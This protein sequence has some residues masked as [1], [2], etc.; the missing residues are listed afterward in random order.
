MN[1][2]FTVQILNPD[3]PQTEWTFGCQTI[4]CDRSAEYAV[5]LCLYGQESNEYKCKRHA[6]ALLEAAQTGVEV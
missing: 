2:N 1:K 4:G 3:N 5:R 6:F